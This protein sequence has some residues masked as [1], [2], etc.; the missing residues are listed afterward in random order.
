MV[1]KLDDA[2]RAALLARFPDWRHEPDRDA[3]VRRFLFVDFAQ[4]STVLVQGR[5]ALAGPDPDWPTAPRTIAVADCRVLR[6]PV[7]GLP[8]LVIA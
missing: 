4:Q 7:A 1:Q 8:H 6:A 5:A 3:I 2:A